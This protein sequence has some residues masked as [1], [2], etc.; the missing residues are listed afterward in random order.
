MALG[1]QHCPFNELV[2]SCVRKVLLHVPRVLAFAGTTNMPIQQS[3]RD[4]LRRLFITTG[5]DR[6]CSICRLLLGWLVG[7]HGGRHQV[8]CLPCLSA[9]FVPHPVSCFVSD[10]ISQSVSYFAPHWF[11]T[12]CLKSFQ[13]LSPDFFS[14]CVAYFVCQFVSMLIA[15]S[16]HVALSLESSLLL[17]CNAGLMEFQ[18]ILFC[19][20]VQKHWLAN[21]CWDSAFHFWQII[22]I[23]SER[24]VN[25]P[26][27]TSP[28]C[29]TY[30]FIKCRL[31][32]IQ[33]Q[34]D[35]TNYPQDGN[36]WH[37]HILPT[38]R[39]WSFPY[40]DHVLTWRFPK[41]GGTPKSSKIRPFTILKSSLRHLHIPLRCRF[42]RAVGERFLRHFALQPGSTTWSCDDDGQMKNIRW[43]TQIGGQ[44]G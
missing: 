15:G 12:V 32:S 28:L 2:F 1:F 43:Q 38:R 4:M 18:N 25:H 31:P 10:C 36:L 14:H 26:Y 33:Q 42:F 9:H 40:T 7:S 27:L 39:P 41:L 8:C 5:M 20:P 17:G 11:P 21:C 37:S 23:R 22:P 13:T 35:D 24:S 19:N 34:V 16:Q 29:W 6:F 30:T 44:T 3:S